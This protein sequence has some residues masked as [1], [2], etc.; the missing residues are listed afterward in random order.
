M[1]LN[2]EVGTPG[3]FPGSSADELCGM[4]VDNGGEFH[5]FAEREKIGCPAERYGKGGRISSN[6]R[7]PE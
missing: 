6:Q 4:F 1:S 2:E 3:D 7:E 5:Y